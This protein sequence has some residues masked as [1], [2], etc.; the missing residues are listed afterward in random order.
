M[1][2]N[3]F[4]IG[5]VLLISLTQLKAQQRYLDEVFSNVTITP[6]ITYGSNYSIL[7]GT[8]SLTDLKLD[9]YQ[10]TGDTL[11]ARPLIIY[12]HT[13]SFLPIL[14]NKQA[15]GSRTDSATVEMCKQF[16]RRGY[17]AASI[18]YRLGWNPQALGASGQDIRTG[19]LLQAVYRALQDAKTAVRFMRM[20]VDSLSNIYKIDDSKIVVCGQGSGGY[21]A[22]AYASLDNFSTEVAGL[23]KFLAG[24]DDAT[25]GFVSGQPYVNQAAMGDMDGLGGI[26]PYNQANHTSYS[27]AVNMVVNMGGAM[28]DSSWLEAGDVPIVCFHVTN[29][30]F[31]PYNR[32]MVVV[33]T[34]GDNVVY[35]TGSKSVVRLSNT[36]G[37]NSVFNI[38][39]NDPYT[40]RA[41]MVNEGH[42]GLFPFIEPNPQLF[43][44]MDPFD[45]QA[46]PWEWWDTTA[47]HALGTAFG[48]SNGAVDTIDM[49]AH[50]T[51]PNMSK[52]KGLAYIDSIQGYL[53]PRMVQQ[54]ALPGMYVGIDQAANPSFTI[55]VFPN[56][57]NGNFEILSRQFPV[58]SYELFDFTGKSLLS[59]KLNAASSFSI[60]SENFSNG[61]Y[62]LKV[63]TQAGTA[64]KKI[65][66]E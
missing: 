37:N 6:N 5:C 43:I 55:Q 20:T 60:N 10:P 51:N 45:G 31:A 58:S 7:T 59:E 38:P 65:I 27:S 18:D 44:P 8:P 26:A 46:G 62:L 21:V 64:L 33:P 2:K 11:A 42:E 14:F 49:S 3:L 25:Y 23:V 57:S 48:I 15:T 22:L 54:L 66:I 13:G 1:K 4:L 47:L 36:L 50:L 30:P 16:A 53:A 40:T 32:G 9:V 35:V 41:N 19:T 24:A 34:T 56:P 17:V 29:D 12:L 39:Y 61:I 52:A 63:H 28:G